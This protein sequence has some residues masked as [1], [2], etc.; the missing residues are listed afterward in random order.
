M[1]LADKLR[2]KELADI[3]GQ[4]HL[5]GKG[6][7]IN[8]F[9]ETKFIP[10]MIFY[11]P[12]GVGKT[13]VAEILAKNTDKKLFRLNATN[14]SMDDIKNVT[15]EIGK[16]DSKNGLLLYLDEIQSFNKKQQQSLLEYVEKG[17]ITL[18]AST[19]ENPYH[20]VYKALLSR[21]AVFEF[22]PIKTN[23]IID[24]IKNVINK[25]NNESNLM[26]LKIEEKAIEAISLCANGDMR[27]AINLL[28]LAI[29]VGKVDGDAN[30]RISFEMLDEMQIA[31][32]YNYDRNGS[33]HYDLLSA[34]QKSIRGSDPDAAVYYL[35]KIL[36]SG[37]INS[38]CRRLLVIASEDVG[39]AYP[40]AIVITKACVDAALSLGMPEARISLSQATILLASSPKSNSA[41]LAI[42]DAMFDIKNKEDYLMPEFLMDKKPITTGKKN[43]EK[44]L[45]PHNY[46]N[47]YIKQQYLPNEIKTKNYYKPQEN[48]FEMQIQNY[49]EKIKLDKK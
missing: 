37:D 45:Y 20:Y 8:R 11:G 12:P 33:S 46:P 28:E 31:R 44:Y 5:I 26:C 39:L 27:S 49:F 23:E 21:S 4:K 43:N 29:S 1:P 17:E 9:L 19:T 25:Y 13:T 22:L 24:G 40:N 7:I 41:Y 14:S 18:I 47:H 15:K 42:N 30:L 2:P 34:F 36:N 16:I 48:K 6:K 3:V 32:S 38:V 35:A 10:N